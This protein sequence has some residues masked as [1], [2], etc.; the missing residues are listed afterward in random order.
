MAKTRLQ[1]GVCPHC[2]TE[3]DHVHVTVTEIYTKAYFGDNGTFDDVDQIGTEMTD[4]RCPVCGK[5]LPLKD[6]EAVDKFL[7]TKG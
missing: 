6:Q 1:N 2:R 5:N 4:W 3:I 7:K